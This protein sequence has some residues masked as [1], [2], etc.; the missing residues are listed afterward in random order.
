MRP[1]KPFI[2][3][4]R[5]FGWTVRPGTDIAKTMLAYNHAR[6]LDNTFPWNAARMDQMLKGLDA[7][8]E[9]WLA[10]VRARAGVV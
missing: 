5:M 9:P 6:K 10:G 3:H 2:Y 8:V 7:I 4:D 1:S